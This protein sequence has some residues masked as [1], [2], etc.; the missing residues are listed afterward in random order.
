MSTRQEQRRLRLATIAVT[1]LTAI[2]AGVLPSFAYTAATG[3]WDNFPNNG[4]Y[5]GIGDNDHWLG[6][7]AVKPAGSAQFL[8]TYCIHP[9][10]TGPA[11]ANG[12]GG[13]VRTG[14][15]TLDT[16]RSMSS[17]RVAKVSY[18]MWR[19]GS[20]NDNTQAAAVAAALFSE[21]GY[22]DYNLNDPGSYGSQQATSKGVRSLA[23]S[24]LSQAD[25]YAGPY[26]IKLNVNPT[27]PVKG[28]PVTVSAQLISG[29]GRSVPGVPMSLSFDGI[30]RNT[31]S[32]NAGTAA[33]TFTNPA[34]GAWKAT[35]YAGN[36]APNT[37]STA[38]PRNGAAQEQLVA[39]DSAHI[40]NVRTGTARSDSPSV[41]TKASDV[42]ATP[43]T[44]LHDV[45][46]V[47]GS[48]PKYTTT[49]TATLYGPFPT[50]PTATD[51]VPGKVAG[52]VQFPVK[53]D[54]QYP[55]P[56]ITPTA[57][58][59]YTWVEVLPADPATGTPE[60]DTPCGV[61]VET[62]LLQLKPEL[63]TQASAQL[64]YPGATLFDT[65]IVSKA[66]TTN[67]AVNWALL[68]PIA[69]GPNKSCANLTW[70]GAPTADHGTFTAA[71]DG[72]YKTSST[73]VTA[74]GC[75]TYK[76]DA[77]ATATT[78]AATSEP[79][80]ETETALLD[81]HQPLFAT[82]I[83]SQEAMVGDKVHDTVVVTGTAGTPI[84]VT[85]QLLGPIA[86]NS[87]G[88]CDNLSWT[89]APVAAT[90]T[91][92]ASK[93]GTY[94]TPDTLLTAQG[95]YTY[96]EN[97]PE[98]PLVWAGESPA[99]LT[100][101]T[102][103]VSKH[104]PKLI[105]QASSQ[106]AAA[107]DSVYDTVTV[108]DPGPDPLT[109]TWIWHG[110]MPA[111]KPGDCT[112]IAWT[113]A[114]IADQG[115]MTITGPG[116]VR[117]PSRSVTAVGCYTF[118]E[119]IAATNSSEAAAS[120]PGE[121]AETT[122]VAPNLPV[123]HT[124]ASA[125]KVVIGGYLTDTVEIS[126]THGQPVTVNWNLLGPIP[127]SPTTGC[128]GLDWSNAPQFANGT[129]TAP[130]DGT[131]KTAASRVGKAGCYTYTESLPA[132]PATAP[133]TTLPGIPEETTLVTLHQ[134]AFITQ[135]SALN[136]LLA[137]TVYDTVH[138]SGLADG[139]PIRVDWVLYGPVA[140]RGFSCANANWTGKLPIAAKGSFVA[141]ANGTYKTR[142][143]RVHQV[144]CFTYAESSAQT[145]TNEAANSKPGQPAETV[146]ITRTPL[147]RTPAVP[148][149]GFSNPLA[150]KGPTATSI[151]LGVA[152]GLG[153]GIAGTI[154]MA[155]R[156]RNT[157]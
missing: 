133:V 131:Y 92:N 119:S 103:L 151:W 51:C 17:S 71:G 132:T 77:P 8:I 54:G 10:R 70:T 93:D 44:P 63:A 137:G 62:T 20:T 35:V 67:L 128:A 150:P 24:Y 16:G 152:G 47:S 29:S 21:A 124:T 19:W 15:I 111:P 64:V 74:R 99:G 46:T 11:T 4:R 146:L 49:A 89:G 115:T 38:Y 127:A 139:E 145:S 148:T 126:R 98:G 153:F 81:L 73:K 149:G 118:S 157:I 144:G 108:T 56:S 41:V 136:V 90:S 53:A 32:N 75:Y 125:Q 76:E 9:H 7:Y 3:N 86:P 50:Q 52:T 120:T 141:T 40:S 57:Y 68:G 48:D 100:T 130:G 34:S 14:N 22:P 112:G 6:S 155:R 156:R 12:Y 33:S 79:G 66:G 58:G 72:A 147:P 138:V 106:Q 43:G 5:R 31:T 97:S 60:V 59:Y 123:V 27:K 30:A 13:I 88:Q 80:Q 116:D 37:L 122:L 61:V 42:T 110:P 23:L 45:V 85:A 134:P 114:P 104:H 102:V 2:L 121:A 96:T 109:M 82:Q 84:V 107:G 18:I 39:G 83:S 28:R 78:G 154:I 117:T 105:T 101:E 135:V 140:P 95:C 113:K 65:V 25:A 143:V 36:V 55:T 69:P 87:S 129:F 94:Q 26:T 1:I 142:P 91:F